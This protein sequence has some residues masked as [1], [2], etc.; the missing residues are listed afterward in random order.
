MERFLVNLS[1]FFVII[2]FYKVTK[3]GLHILQLENY[4]LDRYISWMKKHKALIFRKMSFMIFLPTL[5]LILCFI[6]KNKILLFSFFALEILSLMF[7]I[8]KFKSAPEKKPFVVTARIIRIYF[9]YAVLFTIIIVLANI[10]D[11][12][13]VL[14]ITN[15]CVFFSYIFVFIVGVINKPVEKIIR[16]GFIN[17]AKKK[18]K[19]MKDL[20][21]IGVTGSYGKTSTKFVINSILSQKFNTLVTPESYNTTMGVV[22]TINENLKPIHDVFICEMGAKY[23]GDIKEIT[24]IVNPT[25]GVLTAIGPQH[26]DTFKSIDNVKKTKLELVDSLPDEGFAFV[27]WE[28]QNIRNAGITKKIIKYGLSN[29]ADYYAINMNSNERGSSFDVVLPSGKRIFIKT[30]LLGK[31]NILNIVAGVAVADTFGLNED[32]IKLGIKYIRP[33][34][35]RLELKQN[36]NGS[37]II[38]DAY[39][40]NINGANMALDVLQSFTHKKRVLITPGIVEL[41]DKQEEIN[42]KFG[43]KAS[44]SAD[45]IILVGANQTIPIYKGIEKKKFP[46]NKVFIA[47][48][49]NEALSK[50]SEIITKDT[51][52]L[53][54]NDL[55]DNYL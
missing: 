26:L 12:K 3:K 20:K 34:P 9:T 23:V 39:N 30:K 28:D 4:Y 1:L 16:R 25:F 31:L 18:L 15:I 50:M 43:E 51:V 6:F 49:L 42:E 45:F 33:V 10:I 8:L 2:Y 19:D 47:K 11:Y 13:P 46:K 29:E 40:S 5:L 41:G 38:D 32:E 53:F 37:L 36:P 52:I 24:D 35:H 21:V 7:M 55:P 54:E 22:R 44:E 14:L 17:Q 27:N 48:N